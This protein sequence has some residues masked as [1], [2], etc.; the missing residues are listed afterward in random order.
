MKIKV[1]IVII[2]GEKREYEIETNDTISEI[3]SKIDFYEDVPL[4]YKVL[5]SNDGIILPHKEKM[6]DYNVH[7]GSKL[8][9]HCKTHYFAKSQK[10]K[11]L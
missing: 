8:K 3:L 9:L 1:T 4:E 10:L 11:T 5:I 2:N 6:S 7:D